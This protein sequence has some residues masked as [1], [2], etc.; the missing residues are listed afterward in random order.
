VDAHLRGLLM[1][2]C[3]G[4]AAPAATPTQ[5]Q[6]P[7]PP[8]PPPAAP[9]PVVPAQPSRGQGAGPSLEFLEF[10]GEFETGDGR[11]HDPVVEFGTLEQPSPAT[12][13]SQ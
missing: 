2:L 13:S 9:A 11:W 5:P 10:L 4:V 7:K 12:G 8:V 3:L 1:A 6:D